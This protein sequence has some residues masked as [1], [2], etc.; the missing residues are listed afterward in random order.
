VFPIVERYTIFMSRRFL[1]ISILTIGLFAYL[2][3]TVHVSADSSDKWY[4]LPKTTI[5]AEL[6]HDGSMQVV[7]ERTYD[8]HGDYRFAYRDFLVHSDQAV[9]PMRTA[10]Y[11]I[12]DFRV[13][14]GAICFRELSLKEANA[15]DPRSNPDH[16]YVVIPSKDKIRLQWHF[17]ATSTTNTYTISYRVLNAVTTQ[18]DV[19]ELYWQWIGSEWDLAHKNV[20]ATLSFPQDVQYGN[21]QAWAHGP[22]SGRVSI[23]D[24]QFKIAF[25]VPELPSGQFWEGRVIWPTG[26]L[27]TSVQGSGSK[28]QIVKQEEKFIKET[29]EKLQKNGDVLRVVWIFEWVSF[30]VAVAFFIYLLFSF[31]TTHK[32]RSLPH[33]FLSS[34]GQWE[35]PSSLHPLQLDMLLST[36][37]KVRPRAISAA[38]LQLIQ[39]RAIKLHRSDSKEGLLFPKYRY[40]LELLGNM[41]EN[42]GF[43]KEIP[44]LSHEVYAFLDRFTKEQKTLG[45][46]SL[47]VIPIASMGNWI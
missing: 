7:E 46:K 8:F 5:R 31:F 27:R 35:P 13:C 11:D 15:S 1:R 10:P 32:D 44:S 19:D 45:G 25:I 21:I 6:F 43:R 9:S 37:T 24:S 29:Q 47:L 39:L 42:G 23:S 38:I 20:S 28:A 33:F 26:I 2:F 18:S 22:L 30:S 40:Y 34:E 16:T 4:A 12:A 36:G 41:D 14:E 3:P 17:R